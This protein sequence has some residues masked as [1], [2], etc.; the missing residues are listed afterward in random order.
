[1]FD[2]A[3]PPSILDPIAAA[4]NIR[5]QDHQ[6]AYQ[7]LSQIQT[8]ISEA[9]AGTLT[10]LLAEAPDP[11]TA[12][13]FFHRFVSEAS[14]E[15][16]RSLDFHPRLM[17]YPL[18]VFSH[19]HFLSETL[20][21]NPDLLTFIFQGRTLD[22]S[23]TREDFHEKLQ[24]FRSRVIA[25]DIATILADFKKREYIRIL[26]RDVLKIATLAETTSEISFLAD[27]LI[28]TALQEAQNQLRRRH[29]VAQL[30]NERSQP[31][32]TPFAV[33]SLGK[34]GGNELNYS[35]D[36]DLMFIFGDAPD[37]FGGTFS[38]REYF[39]RLAQEITT[40][41]SC[42][43]SEGPVF[44]IDLRLRPQGGE[45][46]LAISLTQAVRYYA[47]TAK[48]WELQALIKARFSAG[49]AELARNFIQ[50]VRPYVYTREANFAA[51]KTA[52]VAREKMQKG[53]P[54]YSAAPD[55]AIDVK[56]DSGG[57]RDIEFLVQCLQRV[58]GGS[59]PWLQSGGTLFSLHKLHDNGHLNGAE[60]H[61]LTSAYEFLRV[62]EHRLQLRGG[63]Q[64]HR[65]PASGPELEILQR[66][67]RRFDITADRQQE[68][69]VELVHRRMAVVS[70][71]YQRVI[72]QQQN[73]KSQ[74]SGDTE[75]NLHPLIEF[76]AAASSNRQILERLAADAPELHELA[77]RD[78]LPAATRKN[79]F[80]FFT[81][82][83]TSSERYGHV[84]R[85]R[86]AV[87]R[88][89]PI[90]EVSD[91]LTQ[92]L[93]RHP[94]EIASLTDAV[95][96]PRIG[97]GDLF[98]VSFA[99]NRMA[100]PVFAYLASSEASPQQKLAQ[101]RRHFR[102]RAFVSGSKDIAGA[103]DVFS[104]CAEVTSAADDAIAAAFEIS[105]APGE[106]AVMALGRLGSGELDLLSD[107]DL[108]FVCRE[109]ECQHLTQ[110]VSQI[111]QALAAYT[112]D[113]M[114]FPVDTR[115]RPRGG[116]GE[117]LT[118][119][120]RLGQYF[121]QEAHAWEALTYTKL[122][123]IAGSRSLGQ[124]AHSA[125]GVLFDRFAS[126]ADFSGSVRQ[127]RLKLESA[128]SV[129]NF[130][131]SIGAIYDIDF[132]TG[133]LLV[134][135]GIPHKNGSIRD[136][137]WRCAEAGLLESH[138]A[139]VLDHGGELLRTVDHAVRLVTGRQHK[140]LPKSEHAY[141]MT[142]QLTS[143][144]LK[145]T[146]PKGLEVELSETCAEIRKIYNRVLGV[147]LG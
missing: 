56:I 27:A 42:A 10:V 8:C 55:S 44:R 96:A 81:A 34:L 97:S 38:Q 1:M 40:I 5:F 73:R 113:G 90:F 137:I 17:H 68:E 132:L 31:C 93:T 69:F 39:I 117:L 106:L 50:S 127:M 25:N 62:I 87:A 3:A 100:D 7:T 70:E 53:R 114:V 61:E 129:K 141:Q 47:A 122:R 121:K 124:E 54:R 74:T 36:I 94:E 136:R 134:K 131:S 20:V 104:S 140:W 66:S 24:Y 64:T 128:S 21:R 101:L 108:L 130:K 83:L 23:F 63:R 143:K 30:P 82:A 41:L 98:E 89:L 86:P 95:P 57:I 49:N 76:S 46:E 120:A 135:N 133:F 59:E 144:I 33:L 13:K 80:H 109:G 18:I 111:V 138:A 116:E 125:L 119:P 105:A 145:R 60:F 28:E 35:S 112:R 9:L 92:L 37:P 19:S 29:G 77:T 126:D 72:Y 45:G 43:T 139:A 85:N 147:A 91:Y 78:D 99:Q 32:E 4:S 142:E 102:H 146:F 110:A 75:F 67:M 71:I 12:L 79:L 14:P 51:I 2:E 84:L 48:D 103:R 26:L 52:L 6:K 22:R 65:M 123:F 118:T 115:L 107:A 58:Y 11:D 16:L 88:A 15:I